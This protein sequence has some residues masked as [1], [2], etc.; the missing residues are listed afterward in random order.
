VIQSQPTSP[1]LDA[2]DASQVPALQVIDAARS[3]GAVKA[4]DGCSIAVPAGA[5]VGLIGPN[6]S[7]KSTLIEAISGLQSLDRGQVLLEGQPI[8]RLPAHERARLGLRR[9]FQVS[10]LWQQLTVTENLMASTPQL[11]RDKLWMT[12][13]RY[14]SLRGVEREAEEASRRVLH[15]LGLWR[16]RNEPASSLSGGQGRLLEFG[17]ILVSGAKVALLDEPLAG[18][19]PV[20]AESVADGIQELTRQGISVLIV[21]HDLSV[22]ESLCSNVYGMDSGRVVVSGSMR[23]I[24]RT[25]FF[26]EAYIGRTRAEEGDR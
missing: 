1:L 10:R 11:G 16:L 19:N 5:I 3:F 26:A 12:Y 15:K 9:S 7:G 20:M 23:D 17:R 24:A 13:F 6:G 4:L 2:A 22:I 21:E 25:K 18:V 8:G 14:G